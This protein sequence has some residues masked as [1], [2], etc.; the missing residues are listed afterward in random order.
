MS[1]EPQ[2]GQLVERFHGPM[3]DGQLGYV[4]RES[5]GRLAV[6][7]D[8]KENLVVPYHPDI[9]RPVV[10]RPL[11]PMQVARVAYEADRALR[12][13]QGEYGVP[14]WN[15]A[16]EPVRIAYMES[17]PPQADARRRRLYEAL[18]TALRAVQ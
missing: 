10:E 6:K 4:V 18:V 2:V 8:R 15:G 17:G 16:R 5:D 13:A 1:Q 7:L 3:R 11:G 14:E 12:F 9:W